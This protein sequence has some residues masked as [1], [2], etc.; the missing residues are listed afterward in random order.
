[1]PYFEEIAEY[2]GSIINEDIT[3]LGDT[4]PVPTPSFIDVEPLS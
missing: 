2:S 1:M 3:L 4:R